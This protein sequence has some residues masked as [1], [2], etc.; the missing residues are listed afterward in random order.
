[1]S[2]ALIVCRF[3]HFA[4]AMALFGAT[5]FCAFLAPQRLAAWLD[6]WVGS[7]ALVVASLA[8]AT[9][10][11]WLL[12]EAAAMGEGWSDALNP[13]V[14]ASVLIETAFGHVWIGRLAL[15][16]ALV[17]VVL[18][19]P[20]QRA[21]AAILSGLFLASLGLVDHAAMREGAIGVLECANQAMHLLCGG[22]WLGSLPPLLMCLP[23]LKDSAV[24][25]EAALALRRFSSIGHFAVAGVLAT[26]L[27]NTLVILRR[28]PTDFASPYQFLLAIKVA[29]VATMVAIAIINRY[30]LVPRLPAAPRS[31]V[32]S[33]AG[34]SLIE[35]VLGAT[36]LALVSAFATFEPQ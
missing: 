20:A 30:V 31:S 18:L 32:R 23:L 1:M 27:V 11:G 24:K 10:A 12:L 29:L 33:L 15:G 6:R 17:G 2:E 25:G 5:T 4:T 13:P 34:L 3:A 7:L 16:L 19:A 14:I 35:I 36:V 8:V 26:G 9:A 21:I 22:F 28:L